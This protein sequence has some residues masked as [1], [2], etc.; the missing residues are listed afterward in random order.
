MKIVVDEVEE[1]LHVEIPAQDGYGPRRVEITNG[2]EFVTV[3]V[4]GNTVFKRRHVR[5]PK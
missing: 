5:E 4:D 3:N 1:T 2:T